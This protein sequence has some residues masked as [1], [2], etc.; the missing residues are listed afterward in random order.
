MTD[1]SCKNNICI[2]YWHVNIWYIA[3]TAAAAAAAVAVF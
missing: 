2:F 1:G 3:D